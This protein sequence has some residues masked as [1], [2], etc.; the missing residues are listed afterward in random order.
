M[1]SD[2][3]KPK[4]QQRNL[5]PLSVPGASSAGSIR[6]VSGSGFRYV[7]PF[8]YRLHE[9]LSNVDA[10]HDSS[11][12]S[13]LPDGKHFKVH[14]PRRFVECVIP[15]AFKQ[16][17]LKSF[18]RQLHL[19]G[20][21]RVHDGIDKGAY[22]HEKFRRDDRDLC[23][24][25]SR[26]KAPKRSRTNPTIRKNSSNMSQKLPAF[27]SRKTP[28][29]TSVVTSN[30]TMSFCPGPNTVRIS[31]TIFD[32][33]PSSLTPDTNVSMKGPLHKAPISPTNSFGSGQESSAVLQQQ[34]QQQHNDRMS[35]ASFPQQANAQLEG[36]IA[37]TCRW[38]INA[39]VPMSAFD[40]VAIGDLSNSSHSP[41]AVPQLAS[42][43]SSFSPVMSQQSTVT[44]SLTR[45][46][47]SSSDT[48]AVAEPLQFNTAVPSTG[49]LS[50]LFQDDVAPFDNDTL[51]TD[52]FPGENLPLVDDMLWAL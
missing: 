19:Y 30:T 47:S 41:L 15:S 49:D 50:S 36:S 27:Q 9:M 34:Q 24:A 25:I 3:W 5:A 35:N 21:Q 6:V 28:P 29:Q 40:P 8:P 13:W 52:L 37:D 33:V 16:K 1:I 17:S 26:T 18:Q 32:D 51:L 20:F 46:V 31:P 2:L 4:E 12:V 44:E 43:K 22:Y 23:L 14:D 45:H 11:I 42:S 39:G 7:V 48:A 10:K 38:L